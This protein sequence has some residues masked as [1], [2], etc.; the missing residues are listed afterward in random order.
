[1]VDSASNINAYLMFWEYFVALDIQHEKSTRHIVICDLPDTY[2]IFSTLTYKRA[3][4]SSKK[5][6]YQKQ[7]M[8]FDFLYNICLKHRILRWPERDMI[9]NVYRFPRKVPDILVLF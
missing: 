8:C 4:F 1:M 7:N 6:K 2:N 9:K 5:K 3:Q